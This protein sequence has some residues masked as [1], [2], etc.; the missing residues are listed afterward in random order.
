MAQIKRA[1]LLGGR[2]LNLSFWDLSQSTTGL[3]EDRLLLC[4]ALRL[5]QA[6]ADCPPQPTRLVAGTRQVIGPGLEKNRVLKRVGE[7][8]S[9]EFVKLQRG[10]A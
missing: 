7:S 8:H 9:S 10:L 5:D 3:V 6:I 2:T 1:L 4:L